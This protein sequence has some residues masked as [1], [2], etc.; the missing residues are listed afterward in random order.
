MDRLYTAILAERARG[1]GQSRTAALLRAGLQK[2]AKKLGEEALEL[3]IEALQRDRRA[4]ISES[5]DVL[6]HLCVLWAELGITPEDVRAE[7]DRREA[8]MGIAEKLPKKAG[9]LPASVA[10]G[11][12][13]RV[14]RR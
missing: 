14:K 9:R 3:S 1:D 13:I 5:A 8:M 10:A 7:M 12:P 11:E 6:Y 4:A 2:M